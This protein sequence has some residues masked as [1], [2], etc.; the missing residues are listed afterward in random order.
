M[1]GFDL[2]PGQVDALNLPVE[3]AGINGTHYAN[4]LQ[5]VRSGIVNS[6]TVNCAVGVSNKPEH[7][8]SVG[9]PLERAALMFKRTGS[10]NGSNYV[11]QTAPLLA[12]APGNFVSTAFTLKVLSP[13]NTSN[14]DV[15]LVSCWSNSGTLQT[16]VL[17]LRASAVD[18]NLQFRFLST[19]VPLTAF[20]Y[21]TVGREYHIEVRMVR[22]EGSAA[23]TYE[24]Q[25]YVDGDFI[26]SGTSAGAAYTTEGVR[27]YWGI[28]AVNMNLNFT[29]LMSDLIVANSIAGLFSSGIGP[30]LILPSKIGAV[31][32]GNWEKE[33]NATPADTLTDFDDTTFYSSPADA[34]AMSAKVAGANTA[35]KALASE[36]VIRASR[37]RD[38]G[39]LLTAELLGNSGNSLGAAT[40]IATG[41]GY[42]SYVLTRLEGIAEADIRSPTVR[43]NASV[44]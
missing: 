18:T 40:N 4:S 26:T 25:L 2:Y 23:D 32:P 15:P 5:V 6:A 10:V 21:L 8:M 44:P 39:R 7:K 19:V 3:G 20:P 37:D 34:G 14:Q 31:T 38:A 22:K 12:P 1:A 16:S 42:N 13:C 36:V 11:R 28:T 29:V 35:Y 9:T 30:Q 41:N 43:L 17:M 27:W 33:G 24:F